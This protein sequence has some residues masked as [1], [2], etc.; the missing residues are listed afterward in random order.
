MNPYTQNLN[1]PPRE[2]HFLLNVHWLVVEKIVAPDRFVTAN[3]TFNEEFNKWINENNMAFPQITNLY[4]ENTEF[5]GI[6]CFKNKDE[7][8]LFKL[9]WL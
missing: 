3:P 1:F 4:Y 5:R 7:A 9:R 8:F 2:N 6:L